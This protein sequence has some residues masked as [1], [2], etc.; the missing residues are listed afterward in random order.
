MTD[1]IDYADHRPDVYREGDLL[2]FRASSFGGCDRALVAV[3]MGDV[4]EDVPEA[5]RRGM[6]EG[7]EG[8]AEI[9]AALSDHNWRA[10][11][12]D[13][14]RARFPNATVTN[15][16]S[17]GA[18]QV[19]FDLPAGPG[20]VVRVHPDA[21]AIQYGASGPALCVVEGKAIRNPEPRVWERTKYA[22]Q[23]SVQMIAA[24]KAIGDTRGHL[25]AVYLVGE[26]DEN[27]KVYRSKVRYTE[28]PDP[29]HSYGEI[30]ARAQKLKR[31]IAAAEEAGTVEGVVECNVAMWPC[32]FYRKW[33]EGQVVHM[34]APQEDIAIE[35]PDKLLELGKL[36][37]DL[38]MVGITKR[39]IEAKDKELKAAI[40]NIL[41]EACGGWD[42]VK[43]KAGENDG[44]G[45]AFDGYTV[46]GMEGYVLRRRYSVT[47]PKM[48]R[49]IVKDYLEVVMPKEKKGAKG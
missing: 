32:P 13:E 16:G 30:V 44:R 10:L 25:P 48:G 28:L 47:P 35:D 23:V 9:L 40:K 29:L 49:E 36:M 12:D 42:A 22:W 39:N 5:V 41:E 20:C 6:D 11:N 18:P 24:G 45:E 19:E 46:P 8:E 1:M 7:V 26:K 4:G 31:M 38:R 14:L 43:M 27:R 17:G 37:N 15:V 2:V 34:A 21:V 33:H 3:A